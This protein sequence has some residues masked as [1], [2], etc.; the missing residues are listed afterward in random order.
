MLPFTPV[1]AF[2]TTRDVMQMSSA[3][4]IHTACIR[5][6]ALIFLTAQSPNFLCYV[7]NASISMHRL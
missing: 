1:I 6:T 4:S 7:L 2:Q 5:L 3:S